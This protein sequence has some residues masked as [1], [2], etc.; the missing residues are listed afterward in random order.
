MNY[1]ESILVVLVV[2]LHPGA[3]L[4]ALFV[5]GMLGLLVRDRR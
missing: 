3:G 1:L 5:T 2:G 4:P